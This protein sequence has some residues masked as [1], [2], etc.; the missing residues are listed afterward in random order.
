MEDKIYPKRLYPNHDRAFKLKCRV[1]MMLLVTLLLMT[2]NYFDKCRGQSIS[3][4]ECFYLPHSSQT[5]L[6]LINSVISPVI[7]NIILFSYHLYERICI[8]KNLTLQRFKQTKAIFWVIYK[9][10]LGSYSIVIN[11]Q[12]MLLQSFIRKSLYYL[13]VSNILSWYTSNKLS[14][15]SQT[16]LEKIY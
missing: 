15:F 3:A 8:R 12:S 5:S 2:F 16:C 11:L 14:S 10:N 9:Y 7:A 4:M 1:L 6:D 13:F